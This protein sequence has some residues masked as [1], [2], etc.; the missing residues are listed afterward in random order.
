M[1]MQAFE[2]K[3]N[4]HLPENKTKN[5]ISENHTITAKIINLSFKKMIES[6]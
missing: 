2:N 6:K 5:L 3:K 4:S 1:F